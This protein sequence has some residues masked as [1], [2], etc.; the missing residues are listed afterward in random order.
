MP[1]FKTNMLKYETNM[2]S[3]FAGIHIFSGLVGWSCL[4][5]IC[6]VGFSEEYEHC[7]KC[8]LCIYKKSTSQTYQLLIIK[9]I[10]FLLKDYCQFL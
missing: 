10:I 6:R 1:E 9:L 2:L 4:C 5:K 3:I 8:N 7:Q